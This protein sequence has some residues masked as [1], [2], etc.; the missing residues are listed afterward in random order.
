M[1][2][3]PPRLIHL[4]DPSEFKANGLPWRTV[5][6]ARWAYRTRKENGLEKAFKKQG[7]RICLDVIKFHEAISIQTA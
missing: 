7:S 2:T 3:L 6:Q 5:E 1:E 4:T